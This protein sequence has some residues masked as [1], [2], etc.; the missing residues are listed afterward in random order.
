VQHRDYRSAIVEAGF[1][2]ART[3]REMGRELQHGPEV[4]EDADPEIPLCGLIFSDEPPGR[5]SCTAPQ[6]YPSVE[7]MRI[8]AYSVAHG[9]HAKEASIYP[10]GSTYS[11][12][13]YGGAEEV[14]RAI[15]AGKEAADLALAEYLRQ[16]GDPDAA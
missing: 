10:A 9:G 6:C 11:P 15:H 12:M 3:A 14:T 16:Q 7:A 8:G 1:L 4:P 13:P 2:P 5:R